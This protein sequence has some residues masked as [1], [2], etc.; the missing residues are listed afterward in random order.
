MFN[1]AILAPGKIAGKF[2]DDLQYVNGAQVHAVA[3]RSLDRAQ[4]FA[5]KYNASHAV[6]TYEELLNIPDIDCVYIASPH[7][8]HFEHTMMCLEAGLNVLCEKPFA[9]EESEVKQMVAK[10][11]E[12]DVFLME[13]LWTRFFPFMQEVDNLISDGII[14]SP[15]LM[16]ADF[17]FTADY[18]PESRLF[19]KKLGGGA[20]LD[21]GIYPV[22]MA[23]Y[24]FGYPDEITA[25]AEFAATGA[26]TIDHITFKYTDGRSAKLHATL[27]SFILGFMKRSPFP[28]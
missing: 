14:G 27:Y 9:M 26:D 20:L 4:E 28:M 1:W 10:A 16:S 21:I 18:N 6:G 3:S 2:C 8:F 13:A 17:G 15:E 25:S 5:K 7:T 22:F 19:N 11:K 24:Q 12:K 23:L